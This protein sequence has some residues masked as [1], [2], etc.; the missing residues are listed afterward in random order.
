MNEILTA[1]L[2]VGQ[3]ALCYLVNM[4]ITNQKATVDMLVSQG[5]LIRNSSK[6]QMLKD[7][8][9]DLQARKMQKFIEEFLGRDFNVDCKFLKITG[10]A[11][12]QYALWIWKRYETRDMGCMINATSIPEMIKYFMHVYYSTP[13]FTD[14][15]AFPK[16]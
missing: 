5:E 7:H 2:I 3:L 9:F 12:N 15:T 13:Y 6:H 1:I 14:A 16:G 10:D 4:L 11:T 8:Y